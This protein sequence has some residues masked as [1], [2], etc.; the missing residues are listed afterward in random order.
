MTAHAA[1]RILWIDCGAA[2]V[3]GIVMLAAREWIAE[4]HGLSRSLMMFVGVVN[5]VYGSY[6]GSLALRASMGRMPS[7]LAIDVLIA[8]NFAWSIV[9]AA[10][11]GTT[12]G[13][14]TGAA[15]FG[16][17]GCFVAVLAICERRYVRPF[18]T[19]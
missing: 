10:L 15:Q 1:R 4:L 3:A 19:K 2:C 11:V 7:R 12:W 9:C 16:L 13:S 17:E 5:L 8:A 14:S 18:A 6:S